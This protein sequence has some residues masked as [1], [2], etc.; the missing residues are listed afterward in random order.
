MLQARKQE[1]TFLLFFIL[2]FII[3]SLRNFYFRLFE[4]ET[5][6]GV[7]FQLWAEYHVIEEITLTLNTHIISL[8]KKLS[9]STNIYLEK[10]SDSFSNLKSYVTKSAIVVKWVNVNQRSFYSNYSRCESQMLHTKF[11]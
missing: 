5:R 6:V 2:V 3:Y 10:S 11:R 9:V 8:L 4:N 1:D 7:L